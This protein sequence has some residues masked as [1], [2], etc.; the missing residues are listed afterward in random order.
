MNVV[1]FNEKGKLV[2]GFDLI[3]KAVTLEKDGSL[4]EHYCDI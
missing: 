4:K 1:L 2:V 3:F